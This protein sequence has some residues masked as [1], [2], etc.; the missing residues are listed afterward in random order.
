M[1]LVKLLESSSLFSALNKRILWRIADLAQEKTYLKGDYLVREGETAQYCFI[2]V[3]G[4]VEVFR[5]MNLPDKLF[6]ATLGAGEILGELAIID[7]LPRSASAIAL[8]LTKTLAISAWDFKAQ[9]QAYPEIALQ[10]LPVIARRLRDVQ[11]Q[12]TTMNT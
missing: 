3:S 7:G 5:E 9:I 8:E 6:I 4:K 2:I 11:N 10:L 12:L 1:D